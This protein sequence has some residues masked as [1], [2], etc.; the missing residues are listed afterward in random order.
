MLWSEI[1][2]YRLAKKDSEHP[3]LFANYTEFPSER[4]DGSWYQAL[5]FRD[6]DRTYFGRLEAHELTHRKVLRRICTRIIIDSE[7][8]Q[9]LLSD[10]PELPKLW[11]RR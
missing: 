11:K 7:F 8:R 3:W 4:E 6:E 9:S 1:K 5:L 2:P 10:D